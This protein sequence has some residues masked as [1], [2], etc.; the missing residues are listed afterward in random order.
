MDEIH[1]LLVE[2]NHGDVR[3]VERAFEVRDL[4]GTLHTVQSGEAAIDW[5]YGRGEHAGAPSPDLV[6]LDLN[7]PATSGQAVLEEA[8]SDDRLK[9]IPVVVLTGSKSEEDVAEVY[10]KRANAYLTKPIDPNEFTDLVDLVVEFW[11]NQ[12]TLPPDAD[13]R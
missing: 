1:I 5:L 2:D 4:R 12:V 8:K 11:V 10:D 9:R 7:L 6:I 13:G 3:L